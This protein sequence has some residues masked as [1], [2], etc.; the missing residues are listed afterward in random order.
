MG[1]H[2][3][4]RTQW[5]R[6]HRNRPGNQQLVR[7]GRTRD[8]KRR[9]PD[10]RL[11]RDPTTAS[12]VAFHEGGSDHV[13]GNAARAN[14]IHDPV[15]TVSS[16]KRLIGRYFFS[17]EVKKAQA[18]CAYEICR[19]RQSR[20]ADPVR[21]EDLLAARD[22]GDGAARDEG[23]LAKK[24]LGEPMSPRPSSRFPPTST[25]TSARPPRTQARSRASRVLRILNEP[26]AAALAYGFGRGSEATRRRLRP[27]RWDLRHLGARD[28]RRRLRGAVDLRRHLPRRRRLRRSADRPAGRRVHA[29]EHGDQPAQRSASRSRS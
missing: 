16:A 8:G 15:R 24:R 14:I 10:Q 1:H 26:T 23:R 27:R 2:F 22:L 21:E 20:R 18:I 19:G 12:V 3:E 4:C 29:A 28:R 25:T 11:R 13:V 17:E 5:R 9:G 7:G 6:R